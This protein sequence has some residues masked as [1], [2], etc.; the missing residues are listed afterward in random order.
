MTGVY[1]HRRGG[2]EEV[3]QT[4][5]PQR[6]VQY[7]QGRLG[8][9][10]RKGAEPLSPAGREEHGSI[11]HA[12]LDTP[13]VTPKSAYSFLMESKSC[14]GG[15]ATAGWLPRLKPPIR[16]IGGEN[17]DKYHLSTGG[18]FALFPLRRRHSRLVSGSH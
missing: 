14:P 2:V 4:R 18:S 11:R 5:G 6:D 7:R 8:D 15:E 16:A 12:G 10:V 1:D 13:A 9:H 3:C 17:L